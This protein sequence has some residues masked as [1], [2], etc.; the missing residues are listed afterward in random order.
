MAT[1][2]VADGLVECSASAVVSDIPSVCTLVVSGFGSVGYPKAVPEALANSDREIDLTV[3]SGGSAGN[4]IDIKMMA[5][6]QI[7]RRYPFQA[8]KEARDRINGGSVMFHDRNISRLGDEVAFG[9][10]VDADIAIIE[11]VAVGEGWLVPAMSI[12]PTPDYIKAVDRLIV[13]VNTLPPMELSRLHDVPIRK[14]PPYREPLEVSAPDDRIADQYIE[15]DPSKLDAVVRT[16]QPDTAYSYRE[17]TEIDKAIAAHLSTFLTKE[18][19]RNPIFCDQVNIQFGVGSLG[20]ALMGELSTIDFGNRNV[21]YYG[22]LIQDGLIDMLDEGVVKSASAT[23]LSLSEEYQQKL[24]DD[25]ARYADDIVLRPGYVSNDPDMIDRFGVIAVNS[26][27]EVDIYGNVN[28]THID[29][30]Q[31]VSGIGGSGDFNR[32]SPLAITALPSTAGDVPRVLPK[33]THVDHTE[34]D[35]EIVITEQGIADLRGLSPR[36]RAEEMITI[37]HPSYRPDLKS[38]LDRAVNGG[39]NTPHDFDTV[40]DWTR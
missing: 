21:N 30:T 9:Q 36:E 34:H 19:R 12:G 16:A 11:A 27:L 28:S 39:G 37:A 13:E 32:H 2:R 24:F 33:V 20:N 3:V 17:P 23:A 10:L 25:I 29:G 7:A 8:T 38:Y 15:F 22:E 40:L 18:I 1:K 31:I 4:E 5:N 35:V 14:L 26:A 6:G